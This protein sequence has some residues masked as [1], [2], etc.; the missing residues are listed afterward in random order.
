MLIMADDWQSLYSC[1]HE[2]INLEQLYVYPKRTIYVK[3]KGFLLIDT[4][5]V[6]VVL[7][8]ILI[9]NT[10]NLVWDEN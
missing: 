3:P 1:T 10:I 4:K 9:F 2:N 8:F 5:Q 7:G 6:F